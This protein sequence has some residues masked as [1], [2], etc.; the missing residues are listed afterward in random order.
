MPKRK[1]TNPKNKALKEYPDFLSSE[2]KW[3]DYLNSGKLTG[4]AYNEMLMKI[5]QEIPEFLHHAASLRHLET[6][7]ALL[8][9]TI[10][11]RQLQI[12]HLTELLK[13]IDAGGLSTP[14]NK[15]RN[16]H[17]EDIEGFTARDSKETEEE[18]HNISVSE[19]ES[20][21][22]QGFKSVS[23]DAYYSN[24]SENVSPSNRVSSQVS[25]S[26]TPSS[27]RAT[28]QIKQP[29]IPPID[30]W[31]EKLAV[32]YQNYINSLSNRR[33]LVEFTISLSEEDLNVPFLKEVEAMIKKRAE[34]LNIDNPP[35]LSK[36]IEEAEAITR[37]SKYTGKKR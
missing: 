5:K 7:K 27:G 14:T 9:N 2:E 13:L 29:R 12:V 35:S 33:E 26:T 21:S 23:R 30:T 32:Q 15:E 20:R 10:A 18:R 36:Q 24:A 6:I 4:H 25:G 11:E 1:F 16:V 37:S 3:R 8:E 17:H 34:Q 22:A 31:N 28:P 19:T